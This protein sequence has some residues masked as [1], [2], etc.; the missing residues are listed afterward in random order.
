MYTQIWTFDKQMYHLASL[1]NGTHCNKT[2]I[3]LVPDRQCFPAYIVSS[4]CK[5]SRNNVINWQ[6][7]KTDA[8]N[9]HFADYQQ[10]FAPELW[11]RNFSGREGAVKFRARDS[12]QE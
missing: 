8:I 7:A 6:E 10:R 12:A 1:V 11:Q 2:I 3:E 4:C 5:Q 9:C